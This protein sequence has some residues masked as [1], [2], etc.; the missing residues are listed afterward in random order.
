MERSPL[1]YKASEDN[2]RRKYHLFY[3][4]LITK[5]K[6]LTLKP[7][8]YIYKDLLKMKMWYFPHTRSTSQEPYQLHIRV[9]EK[10]I[11]FFIMPI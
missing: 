2:L 11:I 5:W 10:V 3:S 7:L 1:I 6:T 8:L 4:N 9:S